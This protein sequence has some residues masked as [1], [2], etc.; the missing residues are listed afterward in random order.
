MF[1][2][3]TPGKHIGNSRSRLNECVHCANDKLMYDTLSCLKV[4]LVH[5]HTCVFLVCTNLK[6]DG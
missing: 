2:A 1:L 4:F 6:N 3:Y 5:A